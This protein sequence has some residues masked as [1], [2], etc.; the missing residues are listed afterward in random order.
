MRVA[1]IIMACAFVVFTLLQYNDPDRWLW[2]S[3][4]GYATLAAVSAAQNNFPILAPI[5]LPMYLV[6]AVY[7]F[8]GTMAGGLETESI[9]ETVGLLI[10][11]AWMAAITVAWARSRSQPTVK[12]TS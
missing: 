9:R 4:Y 11:A 3:L 8:P 2:I 12:A 10:C 7:W 5:A 6:L 1:N